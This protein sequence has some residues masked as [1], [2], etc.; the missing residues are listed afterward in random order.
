M[1]LL[2]PDGRSK[3]FMCLSNTGVTIKTD[4]LSGVV[5]IERFDGTTSMGLTKDSDGADIGYAQ[6]FDD[7]FQFRQGDQFQLVQLG[8]TPT[9]TRYVVGGAKS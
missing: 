3:M 1:P 7:L 6:D 8:G 9:S 2:G 5:G 4:G